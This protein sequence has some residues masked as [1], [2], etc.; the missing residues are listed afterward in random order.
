[1][2]LFINGGQGKDKPGIM[3]PI[4]QYPLYSVTIAELDFAPVNNNGK[5]NYLKTRNSP[6]SARTLSTRCHLA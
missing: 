4:P 5:K 6:A 2:K 3:I 1:M